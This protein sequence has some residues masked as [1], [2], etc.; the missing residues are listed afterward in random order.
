MKNKL[1]SM[2]KKINE[3]QYFNEKRDA[4]TT[5][6]KLLYVGRLLERAATNYPDLPALI[7]KDEKITYRDLYLRAAAFSD[8]LKDKGLQLRDR[9]IICFENSPEFYIAYFA[10]LQAGGVVAPVNTFLKERELAHIVADATP[11][12]IIT[13]MDRVSLFQEA[14]AGSLPPIVTP[15][16][17]PVVDDAYRPSEPIDLQAYEVA[18]LLY[19][20]GTTGLPKGVMLSSANIIMNLLQGLSRLQIGHK[21]R[22]FGVLPLF[23]VFAQSV[24]VWAAFL[25]GATVIL[26]PKIDRRYILSALKHKPTGFFGVPALYGLMCMLKTAPLD[27]VKYFITGGDAMP[28]KIRAYFELLYR[29]KI[30]NGYGLTETSPV[31]TFDFEDVAQS[32]NVVGKPVIG[33]ACEIRDEQGAVLPAG[34]VGELW[35]KGDNIMLGYYNAPDAT[36]KVLKDGW[37]NT[38]DTM[39]IDP[40]GKLIITGRTKDLIIHKGINVYP[41]EI[42]NVI[43]THPNVIRVGV[44]G[45]KDNAYGEMPIAFVQI[46]QPEDGIDERL[47][48]LCLQQLASYKVPRSFICTTDDLP[49]TATGKVDK[50]VLRAKMP[51]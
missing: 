17:M 26:V 48:A 46:R 10:I 11:R 39:F 30:C 9:V 14:E 38:G 50:K 44:I 29:R 15:E 33:V 12:F 18:A 3:Q 16:D 37:F 24:C 13:S 45:Q 20:S 1:I 32:T 4:L 7:Y 42:E 51:Q 23:H 28:D 6:G 41:Q 40:D 5:D 25:I 8:V 34:Q 22:L 31:L 36:E 21:E 35:V 47:R 43:M 19:T 2:I 49:T 27:S